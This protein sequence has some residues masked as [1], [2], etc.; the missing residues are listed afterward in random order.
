MKRKTI[1]VDEFFDE[2]MKELIKRGE[3]KD[4]SELIRHAI[5]VFI[6]KRRKEIY[7]E[8]MLRREGDLRIAE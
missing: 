4:P 6:Y 2:G 3:F 5:R 7:D 1:F 8:T